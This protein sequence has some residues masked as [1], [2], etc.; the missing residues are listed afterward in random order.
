MTHNHL[1][2]LYAGRTHVASIDLLCLTWH[3]TDGHS[4]KMRFLSSVKR[5]VL[6]GRIAFGL[7]RKISEALVRRWVGGARKTSSSGIPRHILLAAPGGGSV[8]DQ[9]MFESFVTGVEGHVVVIVR[10]D[11]TLLRVPPAIADRITVLVLPELLYGTPKTY[12]RDLRILAAEFGKSSSFSV[13]GADVMDGAYNVRASAR[14]FWLPAFAARLGLDARILGFSWNAHPAARTVDAMLWSSDF[15]DLLAR[16]PKS[17]SRLRDAGARRVKEVADLAF[18]APISSDIPEYISSW[19]S[20]Q[21]EA[22]RPIVVVNANY[23]LEERIDQVAAFSPFVS[24]RLDAG[25]SFILLP[26]DSRHSP[27]DE[28]LVA[29]I[30]AT[31]GENEHLLLVPEVLMPG[32]VVDLASR[33]DFVVTGRMHLAILAAIGGTPAIAISYQGK[34]EGLYRNL[35]LTCFILPDATFTQSLG[36][37]FDDV[38]RELEANRASLATH[39]PAMKTLAAENFRNLRATNADDS[40]A[41]SDL[42]NGK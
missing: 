36:T 1:G 14:R 24:E 25:V 26:H 12:L 13:V 21:R 28:S 19:V 5:S 17:A 29:D 40:L 41:P 3:M 34:I 27:S 20:T 31:V 6:G 22:G 38:T 30:A 18:L 9:A 23:L 4:I 39:V 11:T 35:G 32:E 33:V 10:K 16:D 37:A 15:I 7:E 2:M 8:G 42:R